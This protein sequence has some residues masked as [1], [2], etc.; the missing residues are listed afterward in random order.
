M[1][2]QREK[3]RGALGAQLDL[4]SVLPSLIRKSKTKPGELALTGPT[5]WD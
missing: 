4:A 3:Q 5:S 2:T 1:Y